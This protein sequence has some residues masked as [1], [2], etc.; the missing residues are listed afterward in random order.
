MKKERTLTGQSKENL[1]KPLYVDVC[2]VCMYV[3]PWMIRKSMGRS[4]KKC[5]QICRLVAR[6]PKYRDATYWNKEQQ[7]FFYS[8][9]HPTYEMD[10]CI[11]KL[12]VKY[13]TCSCIVSL[14]A[15][16]YFALFSNYLWSVT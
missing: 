10:S 3:P 16:C 11:M 13:M 5:V 8:L 1:I 14:S 6:H 7:C 15:L 9:R 2:I 12:R 4:E